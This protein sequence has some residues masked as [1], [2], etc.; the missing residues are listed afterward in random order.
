MSRHLLHPTIAADGLGSIRRSPLGALLAEDHAMRRVGGVRE[1][2]F[3]RARFEGSAFA[4]AVT[5]GV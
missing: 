5:E 1:S 4:A 3:S 2:R